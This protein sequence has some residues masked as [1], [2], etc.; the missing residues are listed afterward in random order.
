MDQ[1]TIAWVAA[2]A[3]GLTFL[4]SSTSKLRA[5]GP[6]VL[7][8]LDYRVLPAA[9]ARFY[10]RALP[11][12]ELACGIALIAGLWPPV[13][14]G[15]AVALFGSFFVAVVINL[16][17][18]RRLDCHCFGEGRGEQIGWVTLLR[19][20]VLLACAVLATLRGSDALV[21]RPT[22]ML[23]A[24][25]VGLAIALCLYL[26]G[27]IPALW[28]IWHTPVVRGEKAGL[29]RVS[30]SALPLTPPASASLLTPVA[31]RGHGQE[32]KA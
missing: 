29:G 3:A 28:R 14:G 22:E 7:A 26:L 25:L 18:G 20:C 2:F 32:E 9:A 21:G 8:V 10:A 19:L 15:G 24:A 17:R 23:P 13:V 12:A 6:F 4:A 11:F 5:P 30:L 1:N 31:Q 16:R 27:A